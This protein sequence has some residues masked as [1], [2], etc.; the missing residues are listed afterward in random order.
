[1]E[2]LIVA[3]VPGGF[4]VRSPDVPFYSGG[5]TEYEALYNFA[6]DLRSYIAH[7]IGAFK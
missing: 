7:E 1:M 6:D 3:K 5:T 2:M 4:I